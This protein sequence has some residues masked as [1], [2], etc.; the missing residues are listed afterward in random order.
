MTT[1]EPICYRVSDGADD[2][3]TSHVCRADSGGKWYVLAELHPSI[4]AYL[5][6]DTGEWS[7]AEDGLNETVLF[8]TSEEAIAAAVRKH[9][10]ESAWGCDPA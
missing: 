7:P 2:C 3:F 10:E 4:T 1:V 6:K 9:D 8:D 5:E